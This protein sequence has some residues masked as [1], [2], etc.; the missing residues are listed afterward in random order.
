MQSISPFLMFVGAQHGRCAE[1]VQFYVGL[2]NGE[3]EAIDYHEP[4]GLEPAG[5]VRGVRFTINGQSH[6][7]MDSGHPHAF[8]FTPAFS[9]FIDCDD[10]AEQKRFHDALLDGGEALMPLDNYGFSEAFAW[11]KDRYGVSW[12]LNLP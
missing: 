2:F 12:Q 7:A 6:M 9:F 3:I 11:V 1:A 10:A 4:G 5:T 8:H